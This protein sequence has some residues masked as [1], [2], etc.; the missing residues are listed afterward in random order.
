[1]V[2]LYWFLNFSFYGRGFFLGPNRDALA[3][4]RYQK[5]VAA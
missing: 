4:F 3:I 2:N 5:I 1:M